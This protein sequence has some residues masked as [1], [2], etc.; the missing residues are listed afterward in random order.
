MAFVDETKQDDVLVLQEL[1]QISKVEAIDRL[2]SNNNDVQSAINEYLDNPGSTKYKWDESHFSTDREGDT[3]ETGITFNIQGADELSAVSHVNSAAPTRPPSRA[4]NRS[5]LGPTNTTQEDADLARAIAESAAESG[6]SPQEVG[7][8]E[9]QTYPKYFG[10]A[11]RSEY[12]AESWA[13]VK[14]TTS[15]EPESTDPPP[16]NRRR[17]ADAPAFLR[18]T[19]D[20]RLGALLSIYN[21]I[22]LARNF[23]LQCGKQ[24]RQYGQDTEWWKGKPILRMDVIAKLA[25]GER[26]WG[27]E[28]HPDFTDELHRLVAFLDMSERSYASADNLAATKAI[29][30]SFGVWAP[31][32]EDKLFQALQNSCVGNPDSG[33]EYMTT[34]GKVMSVMPPLSDSSESER[35]DEEDESTTSFIFMDIV[36][37]FDT[38]SWVDTMYDALDHLL[39]SSALSLEYDF[40]DNAKTAVLLHPA[41]VLTLRFGGPGFVK[42]CQIPAVFYA[43]RYMNDRKDL[44]LHFQA[45]IREI[46]RALTKLACSGEERVKCSG[47]VCNFRLQGISQSHDIRDCSKKMIEFAERLLERQKKNVQWRHFEEQLKNGTPYSMD[48]LRLLHTG[49]GPL[50][51]TADEKADRDRWESIIDVCTDKIDQANSALSDSQKKAEVLM[52]YLAVIRKRLTCQENEVDDDL[53]VFRSQGDSYHP[54]Y[55]NPHVK[56]L[57]RGV[58]TTSEVAYVCVRDAENPPNH[59]EPSVAKDQWWKIGYIKGDASPIK[60]EKVTA[61]DVLHAAGTESKNPILVYASEWALNV[62]PI[63]LS[64][65]LRLFVRTDNSDFEQEL[66]QEAISGGAHQKQTRDQA[67]PMQDRRTADAVRSFAEALAQSPS[68][69]EISRSKRKHSISSSVATAGSD[70]SDLANVEL[71]FD[72]SG[73]SRADLSQPK[74]RPDNHGVSRINDDNS[75]PPGNKMLGHKEGRDKGSEDYRQGDGNDSDKNATPIPKMPEMTERKGGV[76]PFLARPANTVQSSID[77]MDLDADHELVDD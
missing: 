68:L 9:N 8:T 61:E 41:E 22:P 3:N 70:R 4:N 23:L 58:A 21:K 39:W 2:K 54:E 1:F 56:Y 28:A 7:V 17:D 16:S 20:H 44:A 71:I 65:A 76:N 47:H 18:Q 63:P 5:P 32:V 62:E 73:T 49:S 45:Q 51:Y 69:P 57:L 52:N 33:I 37:D 12:D 75:Q 30:E 50:A 36:L 13:L 29:D 25:R 34:T 74:Q 6:I 53:F 24:A 19:G 67:A 35:Q 38:Y 72:D 66:A 46:K 64:D 15:T 14:A 55:W 40:P 77:D 48:D 26:L 10:P 11:A 43:D 42:P 59:E 31:D 27:E 60:S